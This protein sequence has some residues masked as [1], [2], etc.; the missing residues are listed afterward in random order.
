MAFS[1]KASFL[2]STLGKVVFGMILLVVLIGL[3]LVFTGTLQAAWQKFVS[4][5]RFG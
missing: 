4:A 5:F 2:E 1:K 3:I